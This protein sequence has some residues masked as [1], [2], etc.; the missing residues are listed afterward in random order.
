MSD[1]TFTVD[2][3][4]VANKTCR[5]NAAIGRGAIVPRVVNEFFATRKTT[6]LDFGAGEHAIHAEWLREQG[7]DVTAHEFGF[8]V[9]DVHDPKALA[10]RYD[11]VF[12]SNVLNVQATEDMMRRTVAQA[13]QAT[14]RVFVANYPET[15]RKAGLSSAQVVAVLESYFRAVELHPVSKARS[16]VF[17]CK[18]P[19]RAA[20]RR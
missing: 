9:T 1:A 16:P 14:G 7:L 3:V 5:T 8:N 13:A 20:S 2:E 6:I 11:V 10:R 4:L 15:P 12:A 18:R 17:V 19:I